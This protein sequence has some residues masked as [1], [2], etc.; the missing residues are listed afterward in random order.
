MKLRKLEKKERKKKYPRNPNRPR[1]RSLKKEIS[2]YNLSSSATAALP[3]LFMFTTS[4][5]PCWDIVSALLRLA[6]PAGRGP[7][8]SLVMKT[9]V[10]QLFGGA[11]GTRDRPRGVSRWV[12]PFFFFWVSGTG[13]R[14][15]SHD[16]LAGRLVSP[17]DVAGLAEEVVTQGVAPVLRRL[18]RQGCPA[19]L[20][21][22]GERKATF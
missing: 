14:W 8:Y 17:T 19:A 7:E 4:A 15:W 21:A 5:E 1:K 20:G 9:P 22:R 13:G 6:S 3:G 16:V 12:H 11:A 10:L 18:R 2:E